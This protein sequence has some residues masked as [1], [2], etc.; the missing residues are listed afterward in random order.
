MKRTYKMY[1][2]DILESMDKIE[3]YTEDLT[4]ETFEKNDIVV[5]AVKRNLE[6]IGEACK[7]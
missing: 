1:V 4:Y 6:I 7:N 5:D 3:R 2:E